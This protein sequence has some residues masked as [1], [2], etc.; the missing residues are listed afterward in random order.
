MLPFANT[1][2]LLQY[3]DTGGF[4]V[5]VAS[6]QLL[7]V[8]ISL[9]FHDHTTVVTQILLVCVVGFAFTTLALRVYVQ[10]SPTARFAHTIVAFTLV[11]HCWVLERFPHLLPF[12]HADVY[13]AFQICPAGSV[14][15]S[16]Q[17]FAFTAPAGPL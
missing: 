11:G 5:T 15:S 1:W 8:F 13:P 10:D 6:S 9:I 12:H 16:F 3:D 4:T 2:R 14:S 17:D 7:L